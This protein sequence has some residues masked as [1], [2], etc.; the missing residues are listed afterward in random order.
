M[1]RLKF[2]LLLFV[3]PICMGNSCQPNG[4]DPDLNDA[5]ICVN[6]PTGV[7]QDHHVN[8]QV[9][10]KSCQEVNGRQTCGTEMV[11]AN[12][13]TTAANC[14][15]VQDGEQVSLTS[16]TITS[17]CFNRKEI[18]D[19]NTIADN[20]FS[21]D[22][23]SRADIQCW[24]DPSN[25]FFYQVCS[26]WD[27]VGND[28]LAEL[29]SCYAGCQ[30]NFGPCAAGDQFCLQQIEDCEEVCNGNFLPDNIPDRPSLVE[31]LL[32]LVDSCCND[33]INRDHQPDN[34]CEPQNNLPSIQ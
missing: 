22:V 2:L 24:E 31:A 28:I 10:G 14:F 4:D 26:Q 25:G 8:V 16:I 13:G 32:N 7:N 15:L 1:K 23:V 11:L 12:M 30:A 17:Q 27:D 18:N 20:P 3:I 9:I 6:N 33:P 29:D 21:V 34:F 5:A 19:V